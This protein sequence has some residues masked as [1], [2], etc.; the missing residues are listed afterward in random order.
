MGMDELIRRVG[1]VSCWQTIRAFESKRNDVRLV[2]AY[3]SPGAA[4][5]YVVKIYRNA[6]AG[7]REAALLRALYEEG[8]AVPRLVA[9]GDTGLVLHYVPG[10]TMLDEMER[11]EREGRRS[12]GGEA[13]GLGL[14][15]CE[16]L[17]TF[18]RAMRRQC[19][20][21]CLF[22]DMHLRNFV[23]HQPSNVLY[24][25][26][27]E[28]CDEG[29]AEQD[30]GMACACAACY[31]PPFTPWRISFARCLL[32]TACRT[33]SCSP[34]TALHA[35]RRALMTLERRRGVRYPPGA[36]DQL[37]HRL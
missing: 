23:L 27:L 1:G 34:E 18:Y 13:S 25:V 4:E 19:G 6:R 8:V 29:M 11:L 10:P 32:A 21:S 3:T 26:D 12:D 28:C 30:V 24:G 17:A 9:D 36:V 37:C 5:L 20:H 16:W 33:L 7:E 35:V 15:L 22:G 14:K 2:R 31:D